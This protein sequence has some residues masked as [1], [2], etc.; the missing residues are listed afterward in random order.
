MTSTPR[1]PLAVAITAATLAALGACATT[2]AP[3]PA[4]AT[5]VQVDSALAPAPRPA[6][7]PAESRLTTRWAADVRPDTVLALWADNGRT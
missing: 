4:P 6:W 2:P 3:E 5:V 7:R 1:F